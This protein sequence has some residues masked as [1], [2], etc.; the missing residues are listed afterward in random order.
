MKRIGVFCGSAVGL[1]DGYSQAAEMLAETLAARNITLLYGGAKVGLMGVLADTMLQLGAE[2]IGIM[3]EFLVDSELAHPKISQLHIVKSMHERKAL[4]SE[5]AD[6]FIMMPGGFGSLDEFFEMTTWTQLGLHKKACGILNVNGYFDALI[7]FMD[8]MLEQGFVRV[9]HRQMIQVDSSPVLLVDNLMK[10][11][12]P[13][14]KWEK[15][16]IKN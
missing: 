8:V 15:E 3:P 14:A 7:Q 12:I 9:P 16:A 1:G 11:V 13:M 4:L 5:M 2:V 10:H 6:A